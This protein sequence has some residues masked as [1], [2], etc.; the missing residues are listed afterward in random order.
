MIGVLILIN[1][2][3]LILFR[4]VHIDKSVQ[5]KLEAYLSAKLQAEIRI[6]EFDFNDKQI[7]ISGMEFKDNSGNYQIYLP[8]VF[9]EYNLSALLFS[10]I[11]RSKAIKSIKIFQPEIEVIIDQTGLT[12]KKN[13]RIP[14]F[15]TYFRDLQLHDGILKII[16]ISPSVSW[17]QT[18]YGLQGRLKNKTFSEITL[19]AYNAD[20]AAVTCNI[21]LKKDR[22]EEIDLEMRH[23]APDSI[24]I[25]SLENFHTYCD[26]DLI[27][28]KEKLTFSGGLHDLTA[29]LDDIEINADSIIFSGDENFSGISWNNLKINAHPVY[30]W[31]ELLYP[32]DMISLSGN[33]NISGIEIS[34]YL[35]DI[36]GRINSEFEISG[37]LNDPVVK[38][39]LISELIEYKDQNFNET[40]LIFQYKDKEIVIQSRKILWFGNNLELTCNYE[41]DRGVEFQIL[42]QSLEWGQDNFKISA[43]AVFRGNYSEDLNAVFELGNLSLITDYAKL[44]ELSF[45]GSFDGDLAA[46]NLRNIGDSIELSGTGNITSQQFQTQL[47][48]K[49]LDLNQVFSQ[50]TLPLLSGTTIIQG[51]P[52]FFSSNSSF[53]IYDQD[54]GKLNGRI[55]ASANINRISRTLDLDISS[56]NL[57]YNYVPLTFSIKANGNFDHVKI[58]EFK[59]NNEIYLRGFID[60]IDTPSLSLTAEGSKIRIRDYLE[61]FTE[62]FV[63]RQYSGLLDFNIT[64][65]SNSVN[66]LDGKIQ[67]EQLSYKKL[68]DLSVSLIL[69]GPPDSISINPIEVNKQE[70]NVFKGKGTMSLFPSLQY[71]FEG[72]VKEIDLAQIMPDLD[73]GGTLSAGFNYSRETFCSCLNLDLNCRDLSYK[74]L[75]IDSLEI[76]AV[77]QDSLL[78]INRLLLQRKDLFKLQGNGVLGFNFLT[79]E[80]HSVNDLLHLNFQGDL[81]KLLSQ[82]WDYI[83][84]ADS[85]TDFFFDLGTTENGLSVKH[86]Q[87]LLE[88]GNMILKNQLQPV[89]KFR[90]DLFFEDDEM[91]I[92]KFQLRMGQGELRIKNRIRNNEEDLILG[93]INLGQFLVWTD[94][95]GI[96]FHL[97]K[98]MPSNSI[99]KINITGQY[100]EYMIITGPF[101][102]MLIKGDIYFANGN[103]IYPANTENLLKIFSR[104][105][106]ETKQRSFD[107]PLK[108]DLKLLFGDNIYYVTYPLN[109]QIIPGSYLH[110]VSDD[111]KFVIKDANFTSEEG[112]IDIFGTQL[113]VD[114]VKVNYDQYDRKIKINATFFKKVADGTF[115]TLDVIKI[116]DVDK[117][118]K[119]SIDF[120]LTSDNPNDSQL[121]ILSLLRYGRRVEEIS[122]PQ[123]KTLLQDEVLT[124]AG[125]SIESAIM[126]PIISP[127]ENW[128]RQTLR[129]DFFHLQTNLIQ[130]IFSRYSSDE[131]EYILDE[132]GQRQ[133]LDTSY[134]FLNNLSIGMGK[135]LT[136]DLFLDYEIQFEKPTE[137]AVSSAMGI[138]HNFSIRY[139]LPYRFRIVYKYHILPFD[140][141][142]SHEILL[143]K[144]IRF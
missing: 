13:N 36:N 124:I 14:D 108:L 94:S 107:L 74:K 31:I 65:N 28:D 72:G 20:S 81:L 51:S 19:N 66:N 121:D 7:N 41:L 134:L 68:K 139:Q 38:G 95:D 30:G 140:E 141:N 101:D 11:T 79:N 55:E 82:N 8:Q 37:S 17:K 87:F 56:Q 60:N 71:Y 69:S 58:G 3:F 21:K 42:C 35:P 49:R 86:G 93:M 43:E 44:D 128:I 102:D 97:P 47:K 40:D 24:A 22:V 9:V 61:Y 125:F 59:I 12:G 6:R 2:A 48:L 130:N 144:S 80:M 90:I 126:D 110:L 105:T 39:S 23:F 54:F 10:R 88:K 26:L 67:I 129:L 53:I 112:T 131:T 143:E 73:F 50:K 137:L 1:L 91:V 119:S 84:N 78:R 16:Y 45:N 25:S 98:Y 76:N 46:F 135:Y 138:Y 29:D 62:D 52:E 27:L 57:K 123:K 99:A 142:N 117:D 89:D 120:R 116:E 77:Q 83:I 136:R 115:V 92:N 132:E 114:Y 122:G 85:E 32:E 133:T 113:F 33:L 118:S 5:T 4:Y 15:S 96:L 111:E 106:S 64:Y 109:L 103:G 34:D 104:I 100:G 63:S 127:V 75:F 18:F 70:I